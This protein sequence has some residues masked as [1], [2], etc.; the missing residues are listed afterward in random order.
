MADITLLFPTFNRLEF[1]KIALQALVKNTPPK[2]VH[3]L[4]VVDASSDDGTA[5]YLKDYLATPRAFPARLISIRERH[6][7]HAMLKA[8]KEARTSLIA[9]VDSDTVV[10]PGWLEACIS[11]MSRTPSIWALGI[12]PFTPIKACAPEERGFKEARFVGGIGL[13]RRAAWDGLRPGIPPFFGWT[14]HQNRSSWK[15]AWLDPAMPVF[16]ADHLP[17]EPF[18]SLSKKYVE[19]KWQRSWPF[20]PTSEAFRWEWRFPDWRVRA[21]EPQCVQDK[22]DI[23]PRYI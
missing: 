16:L 3:R 8:H 23:K 12:E 20:Y 1:T 6:V 15:K 18:S 14:E 7:A 10:P 21:G 2:L 5:E 11:V 19:K 9:K 4:L 17:F 13:F 22:S